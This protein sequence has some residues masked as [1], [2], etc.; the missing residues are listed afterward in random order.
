MDACRRREEMAVIHRSQKDDAL[1]S[2]SSLVAQLP[3]MPISPV[4]DVHSNSAKEASGIKVISS[5]KNIHQNQ[6]DSNKGVPQP[7][8][9]PNVDLA[10]NVMV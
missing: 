7:S 9:D 4:E 5:L 10:G 2:P 1:L 8:M 6:S 3:S